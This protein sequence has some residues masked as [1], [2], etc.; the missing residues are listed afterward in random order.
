VSLLTEKIK[1]F[2]GPGCGKTSTINHFYQRYLSNG[3]K[4]TEITVLTFRK[5]AAADLIRATISYA[6]V[7]ENKLTKH[8]NYPFNLL[9]INRPS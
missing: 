4:S 7:E 6:G 1:I 3:Y 8:V 9:P 5:I 2:G